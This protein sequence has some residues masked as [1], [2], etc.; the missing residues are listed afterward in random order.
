[1]LESLRLHIEQN[2]PMLQ[3]TKLLVACSGGLDSVVLSHLLKELNFPIAL[4]HCN[5][6]L[7]GRES[8]E[9]AAFVEEL[10]GQLAVPFYMNQFDTDELANEHR[11]S[12]Q[13]MARKLRYDW[14]EV[15]LNEIE[16]D[17][18]L[19]AH[20]ADDDL[21]TFFINLSRGT[22]LRGLTGIQ[23]VN[24][25]IVRP[26]LPFSKEEIL[27]YAKL[28]QLYWREDSSNSTSDYLRNSFRL[29]VIPPY[30][31]TTKNALAS[32]IKTQKRLSE[33]QALVEDYIVLVQKLVM[34][35]TNEGFEIDILKINELPHTSA[36]LYEILRPFGF[37][38]WNDI[39]ELLAGQSGK[40][41]FS[42]THRILKDRGVLLLT[43]RLDKS[44]EGLF[45]ISEETSEIHLPIQLR[46][47]LVKRFQITNANTVFVD[48][49]MLSYPLLLRR[50]KEGDVFQPFG[51]EGKKKLSKFFKDEKLSL[52]AKE[53]VWVLCSKNT[54]V[55]VVGMRLDNQFKV[56]KS[57]QNIVRID[58]TPS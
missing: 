10:A 19:T 43:A 8:D 47:E 51:M 35:E 57:T 4:A 37:S 50:W 27:N 29:N 30:K 58:Y 26:L 12:T 7:R 21:E 28:N 55:W 24:E 14:F 33:S 42:P 11:L 3:D 41:I 22:G 34:T 49:D 36:L 48:N 56:S 40:Q 5:F 46:F 15:L 6:S 32:F 53:N 44:E 45:Y 9:D 52:V 38:A 54:I 23:E 17:Y 1:M 20:H 39:S 13:M 31:E 25:S 18:L 16:Y 2:L